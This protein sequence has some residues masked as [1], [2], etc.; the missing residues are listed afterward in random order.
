MKSKFPVNQRYFVQFGIP[1]LFKAYVSLKTLHGN[2]SLSMFSLL[3]MLFV[4]K[5]FFSTL[6]L[7]MICE[8]LVLYQLGTNATTIPS[9]S[10]DNVYQDSSCITPIVFFLPQSL[11]KQNWRKQ[12]LK[13]L[14]SENN[15]VGIA[16]STRLFTESC[17]L[18]R[19]PFTLFRIKILY[20]WHIYIV[21][22]WHFVL[23]SPFSLSSGVQ[24]NIG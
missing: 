22:Y 19:L 4:T 5:L 21:F 10:I 3:V 12:N 7:H 6:Q 2:H 9:F 1:P 11:Y 24:L 8:D 16:T 14:Y 23:C 18:S 13:G 15:G 17:A 20:P